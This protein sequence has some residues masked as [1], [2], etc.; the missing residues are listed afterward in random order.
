MARTEDTRIVYPA[1]FARKVSYALWLAFDRLRCAFYRRAA[2]TAY[3]KA[4]QEGY[5]AGRAEWEEQ[6]GD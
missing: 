5:N 4:F 1:R 6:Y 3:M 2:K